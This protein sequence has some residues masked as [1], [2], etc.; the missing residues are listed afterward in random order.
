MSKRGRSK[1]H[2]DITGLNKQRQNNDSVPQHPTATNIPN[3]PKARS[4]LFND[5]PRTDHPFDLERFERLVYSRYKPDIE[6]AFGMLVSMLGS[7]QLS[8]GDVPQGILCSRINETL[9]EID[10]LSALWSRVSTAILTMFLNPA[11]EALNADGFCKLLSLKPE[12]ITALQAS[13]INNADACIEAFNL[14]PDSET[15]SVPMDDLHKVLLLYSLDSRYEPSLIYGFS[16]LDASAVIDTCIALCSSI[17]CGTELAYRRRNEMLR[18]ICEQL[19]DHQLSERS[20][21]AA[22]ANVYMHCSYADIPDKHAIKGLL[23]EQWRRLLAEHGIKD[24]CESAPAKPTSAQS[25]T[26]DKSPGKPSILILHEWMR[27]GC[28]M[29][30]C[31]AHWIA[32]L[33]KHFHTVGMGL[34]EATQMDPDAIAL[35]DDYIALPEQVPTIEQVRSIHAWCQ[36]HRPAI[37]Y[38]PSIGM[39]VHTVAAASIRL[40]PV[41]VMTGGHPASSCSSVIDRII[42]PEPRN[43]LGKTCLRESIRE[44]ISWIPWQSLAFANPGSNDRKKTSDR[45]RQWHERQRH[46][47]YEVQIAISSSPMKLTHGFLDFLASIEQSAHR[48][49]RWH[50]FLADSRGALHLETRAAIRSRLR[51]ANIYPHLGYLDYLNALQVADI[52]VTPFPFGNSNTHIDYY[53]AGVLGACMQGQEL[54]SIYDASLLNWLR[55]PEDLIAD[56]KN[57]YREI[58]LRLIED[59]EWRISLYDQ[60][61]GGD[62]VSIEDM[63]GDASLFS[64]YGFVR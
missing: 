62:D 4:A 52:F 42:L 11:F 48:R 37:V 55:H 18:Y 1:R 7:M 57:A 16:Q 19:P 29:H 22:T 46:P 2:Q 64:E 10:R 30:R 17:F 40:A 35:F 44:E 6:V 61:Y 25:N 34:K 21:F 20:L 27:S 13:V 14:T 60:V 51:F 45:R 36:E 26:T 53:R 59:R 43:A 56:D 3:A 8:R 9:P 41:Q 47:E 5:D 38:Y 49:M 39:G 58:V 24:L 33:R 12:L 31:Y 32:G 23:H 54:C 50:F 15:F 63:Q 28:A